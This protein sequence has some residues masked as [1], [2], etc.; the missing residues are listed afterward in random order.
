MSFKDREDPLN[1][2]VPMMRVM[3]IIVKIEF[4]FILFYFFNPGKHFINL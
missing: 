1:F 4:W 2:P 3:H